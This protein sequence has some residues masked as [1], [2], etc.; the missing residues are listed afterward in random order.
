MFKRNGT[1]SAEE[2]ADD[3]GQLVEQGR[4]LLSEAVTKPSDKARRMRETF[5]DLGERLAAYQ[6]TAT[7]AARRGARYGKRYAR[8]AD[9]YIHENPWPAVAGG[10]FLGVMATLWWFQRR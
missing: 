1:R 10:I 8:Q 5:D 2:I 4:A 6:D 7:R 3:L 9:E